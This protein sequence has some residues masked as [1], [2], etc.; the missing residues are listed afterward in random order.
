M[1]GHNGGFNPYRNANGQFAA[2]GPS[3]GLR[4]DAGGGKPSKIAGKAIAVGRYDTPRKAGYTGKAGPVSQSRR[5]KSEPARAPTVPKIYRDY[6]EMSSKV[7]R[8]QRQLTQAQDQR[9]PERQLLPI[10]NAL[11]VVQGHRNTYL[12]DMAKY[13]SLKP[14]KE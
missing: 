9:L 6:S 10:R 11:S 8:L 7:D 12:T 13:K 4:K 3:G 14:Y 2:G 1:P 5:A